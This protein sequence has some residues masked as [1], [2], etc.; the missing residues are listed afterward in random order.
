MQKAILFFAIVFGLNQQASAQECKYTLK[1]TVKDFHN[2]ASLVGAT[3]LVLNSN[4]FA[5]TNEQGYFELKNL[6]GKVVLEIRHISCETKK[7]RLNITGPTYKDIF[8]EHHLEELSEVVVTSSSKSEATSIEKTISKRTLENFSDR[9]LGDALSTIS[10]VSTL[11]TGNS[12]VKPIIQGLHSSRL[13]IINNNVRLFDQ[14][15]GDEHAPN[16]DINASGRI[17]IIKGANTLKY[18]SDA[19]GGLI[20]ISPPRFSRIDSIFGSTLTS[21]NSNGNGGLVNS[22]IVKTNKNGFYTRVQANY[23]RF[24]DFNTPDYNLT[25]TGLRSINTSISLGK[26]SFEKGYN[27]F[28][29]FVNNKFGILRSAHVGNVNDLVI[30]INNSRPATIDPFSYDINFPRQ[31]ITHHLAKVDGYKRIKDF[32]KISLQ[33]DFQLNRRKEFDVRR[34]GR[35][36]IPVVDLELITNSLLADVTIDQFDNL[37]VNSGILLRYQN[38]NAVAGTGVRPLIPDFNKYEFGLYGTMNYNLNDNSEISA[39]FRYDYAHISATKR[40]NLTDWNETYNYDELFPEFETGTSSFTSILTRPEFTF[41]NFSSSLGYIKNFDND[42]SLVF[43]YGLAS[44]MPNPS[45]MFSDGLHHST[46]RIEI[47]RLT[48]TKEIANNFSLS[49]EKKGADFGFSINPYYKNID[50]FIQ[51]I[52]IG[53]TTTIRGAYPVWEYNQVNARIFGLDFDLNKRITDAFSYQGSLS[54]L[55]GDNLTDNLPLINMPAT[56]FT[57]RLSYFNEGFNQ[58]TVSIVQRTVF[59]QTRFPDYTFFSFNPVTQQNVFVDLSSTPPTYTL[60]GLQSSMIFKAFDKGNIKFEFNVDNLFNV[61]YR[62]HL[63]RLRFF[64]DELGRNINFKIKINY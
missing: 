29:S 1:G 60:F 49:I 2:N 13:L 26:N 12:I 18:G 63:N 58:L 39:G 21:F 30:A 55:R 57:N 15:W 27:V 34:G 3:V 56:N 6:C 43:N 51:L 17:N 7:L 64:A 19:I 4:Q 11:N 53:T 20:L 47:G 40:Y 59:E 37:E 45:E 25:N 23:K 35:S 48:L 54:L 5:E 44:R 14:E 42:L 31:S 22:E 62:E 16:I 52:P 32:G 9:S 61:A 8:L 24:G 46:A 50:G 36:N 38:N 33:Y 41:H 28:Y 10:G